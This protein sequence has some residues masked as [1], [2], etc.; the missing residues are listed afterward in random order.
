MKRGD[1][2]ESAW[3]PEF[4]TGEKGV[5]KFG[6]TQK[7]NEFGKA[8]MVIGD[9]MPATEHPIDGR[10]YESKSAFRRVTRANGCI[11]VGNDL[12]SKQIQKSQGNIGDRIKLPESVK[13]DLWDRIDSVYYKK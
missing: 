1:P 13:K 12:I 2:K 6:E 4:G 11:E 5:W 9:E 8:A 10:V 3:P 7:V